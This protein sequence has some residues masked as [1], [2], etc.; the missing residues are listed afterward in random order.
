MTTKDKVTIGIEA[1]TALAIIGGGFKLY[2]SLEA[3][4]TDLER[5]VAALEERGGQGVKVGDLCLKLLEDEGRTHDKASLQRIEAQIDQ[6]GC[7]VRV[8]AK[9]THLVEQ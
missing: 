7:T 4:T 5:R 2:G 3:R 8:P 6:F 1:I 9:S